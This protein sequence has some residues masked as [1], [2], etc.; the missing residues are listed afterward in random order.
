MKLSL[1]IDDSEIIRKYARLILESLDYRT[2]EAE[3]MAAALERLRDS[4]PHIIF[5]DWKIPGVDCHE[6]ISRI[7]RLDLSQRPYIVYM[8]TENDTE[9]INH[10]LR[11]GAD[12][13]ILKPFNR[14]ILG[15][16]LQEIKIAA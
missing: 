2:L 13:Y 4:S 9:D 16:K 11:A 5:V 14:D 3:S 10:A 1:V 6:L 8:S 12:D 15:M 7:R